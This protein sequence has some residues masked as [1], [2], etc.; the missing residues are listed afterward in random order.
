MKGQELE[1]AARM[2]AFNLRCWRS[3]HMPLCDLSPQLRHELHEEALAL[4]DEICKLEYHDRQ[5]REAG[6][7]A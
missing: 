1:I 2:V 3:G 4:A 6:S 5:A 7:G